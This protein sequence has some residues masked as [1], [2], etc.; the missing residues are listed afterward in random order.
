MPLAQQGSTGTP[1]PS[2]NLGPKPTV[3]THPCIKFWNKN[4]WTTWIRQPQNYTTAGKT[5]FLE[6]E[7]GEQLDMKT[8]GQIRDSMRLAWNDLASQKRA[9]FTWGR[10]TASVHDYFHSYMEDKWPIL[11]FCNNGWK[12]DELASVTY[13]GY[14]RSYLDNEGNLKGKVKTEETEL[15][16]IVGNSD[17]P[18]NEN[19][20]DTKKTKNEKTKSDASNHTNPKR[21]AL[22]QAQPEV[23]SKRKK[24][25]TTAPQLPDIEATSSHSADAND[26]TLAE[27]GITG[28]PTNNF[29]TTYSDHSADAND[30][31]LAPQGITGDP[32]NNFDSIWDFGVNPAPPTTI[33]NSNEVTNATVNG[34]DMIP[35]AGVDTEDSVV[36]DPGSEEVPSN[37]NTSPGNNPVT[38]MPSN[39]NKPEEATPNDNNNV[40][41]TANS[42]QNPS[43]TNKDI[44][45]LAGSEDN[46]THGKKLPK[47]SKNES[48]HKERPKPTLKKSVRLL[49]KNPVSV[50]SLSEAKVDMPK[51]PELP[52]AIPS[53][54]PAQFD[55]EQESKKRKTKGRMR[56]PSEK[57]GRNLCARRWLKQVNK[58]GTKD[59]FEEYWWTLTKE[60]RTLYDTEAESIVSILSLKE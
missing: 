43:M 53:S 41:G 38:T 30:T 34:G 26:A 24:G 51:L 1:Q 6:G 9:P 50:E 48:L 21:K 5:S 19:S 33:D 7:N 12:L 15:D 57:S 46:N 10:A 60:Q 42:D 25:K 44:K 55:K 54:K 20:N 27:Q 47:G 39:I 32:T 35:V 2:H 58:D 52:A 18:G 28:D 49:L 22:K 45:E 56:V 23:P 4:D 40:S 17:H 16:E 37:T 3:Q 29:T 36:T 14:K 31:T 8:V 59:E 11:R 13:P